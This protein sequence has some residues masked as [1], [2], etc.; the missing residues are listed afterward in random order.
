MSSI[1]T[2]KSK[3]IAIDEIPTFKR[4]CQTL[5]KT[6]VFTN[7]CF[8][9]LHKGHIE[10]LA[11]ASELADVFVV[12]LNTDHSVQIL[13]GPQRPLQDQDS[14]S[15]I[16]ASLQFVDTVV[17]FDEE[18]PYQLIKS[19]LPDVLVK[20]AD[21]KVEDIV[22]YDIVTNNGGKVITIEFVPGYSTSAIV[23]KLK[24]Y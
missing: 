10:Y 15:I 8:D 20:G 3:I 4:F 2:I 16:L 18:T 6:I 21:Y 23:Q 7:G 24:E 11:K 19:L 17:L 22:G 9:I 13:K 14:R 12:G 5:K 1:S